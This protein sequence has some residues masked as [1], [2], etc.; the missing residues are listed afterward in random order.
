MLPIVATI[1][2]F[3]FIIPYNIIMSVLG[4]ERNVIDFEDILMTGALV[5]VASGLITLIGSLFVSETAAQYVVT[6][7]YYELTPIA[8]GVYGYTD[9]KG[10]DK[11]SVYYLD[12]QGNIKII[13]VKRNADIIYSDKYKPYYSATLIDAED[14]ILRYLFWNLNG[15]EVT[16]CVPPG[17]IVEEPDIR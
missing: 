8:D 2:F 15:T 4:K 5:F 16:V 13:E 10:T 11:D 9:R 14:E 6:D 17:S 3:I 12:E 1:A 7:D